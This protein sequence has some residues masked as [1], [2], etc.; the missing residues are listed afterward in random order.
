LL[1]LV[2]RCWACVLLLHYLLLWVLSTCRPPYRKVV[3]QLVFPAVSVESKINYY[4]L[5]EH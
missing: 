4:I 3:Y 2:W 5:T 1:K